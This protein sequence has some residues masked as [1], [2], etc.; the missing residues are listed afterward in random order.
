M[1]RC[2]HFPTR[3]IIRHSYAPIS[4]RWPIA[5]AK[6]TKPK[7]NTF[8]SNLGTRSP[9]FREKPVASTGPPNGARREK[10]D[11]DRPRARAREKSLGA[12]LARCGAQA[13]YDNGERPVGA[14]RICATR[15]AR[16]RSAG[17]RAAPHDAR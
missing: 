14:R 15:R 17:Q 7:L 12:S 3:T 10:I 5:S 6:T 8:W 16:G 11:E 4:E 1:L 13:P 9:L 2:R